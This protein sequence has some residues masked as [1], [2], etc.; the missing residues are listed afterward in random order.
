MNFFLPIVIL[1]FS[2][3]GCAKHVGTHNKDSSILFTSSFE[4]K[5]GGSISDH[6]LLVKVH[7]N[8]LI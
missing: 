2:L 7:L 4:T 6:I 5:T 3:N 8:Y 1:I